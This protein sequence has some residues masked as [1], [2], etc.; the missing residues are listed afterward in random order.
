MAVWFLRAILAHVRNPVAKRSHEQTTLYN[1][2]D[3]LWGRSA[4]SMNFMA[5][6]LG[7]KQYLYQT[8]DVVWF[9]LNKVLPL[10]CHR[11]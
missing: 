11:I 2:I 6:C 3:E 5:I 1:S 9:Y 10:T 8:E 4:H 7:W